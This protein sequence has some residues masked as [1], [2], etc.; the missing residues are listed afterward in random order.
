MSVITANR[1][2]PGASRIAIPAAAAL[3][4]TARA[5]RTE[6]RERRI[7]VASLRP[8]CHVCL[9]LPLDRRRRGAA[10]VT[11]MRVSVEAANQLADL[12]LIGN[13]NF[14]AQFIGRRAAQLVAD[15]LLVEG[16]L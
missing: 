8:N 16:V 1:S 5:K 4:T 14:A 15:A 9:D 13:G 6:I 12:L 10:V 2:E 11:A 7:G 3:V